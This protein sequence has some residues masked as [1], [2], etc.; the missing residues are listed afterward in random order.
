[1][2]RLSQTR[3]K[4]PVPILKEITRGSKTSVEIASK[5]RE[6]DGEQ[7]AMDRIKAQDATPDATTDGMGPD[8]KI[9]SKSQAQSA[10]NLAII[11]ARMNPQA[12]KKEP[13]VLVSWK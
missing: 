12:V 3:L 7:S 4:T 8:R 13:L 11:E 9:I 6:R 5:H 2:R 1:M 10:R